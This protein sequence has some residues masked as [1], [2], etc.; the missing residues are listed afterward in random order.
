MYVNDRNEEYRKYFSVVIKVKGDNNEDYLKE[1]GI[2]MMARMAARGLKPRLIISE[3]GGKWMLRTETIFKTMIVEFTPDIE[4]EETTG[5][6]RELKV[7][8]FDCIDAFNQFVFLFRE[9]FDS[10]TVNGFKRCVI[11]MVK[12]QWSHVG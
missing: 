8:E 12:N 10:K 11:K 2:G 5:D 1:L 9:L 4:F 7:I 3:N 6:G